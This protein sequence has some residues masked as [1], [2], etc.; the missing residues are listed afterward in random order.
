RLDLLRVM[1]W[2]VPTSYKFGLAE[3]VTTRSRAQI[4]NFAATYVGPT[5]NQLTAT[6][7]QSKASFWI[8]DAWG[9]NIGHLPVPDTEALGQLRF[10]HP[11]YYQKTEAN[12]A[13]ELDAILSSRASNQ[14]EIKAA[15]VMQQSRLGRWQ[16]VG[17]VRFEGTKTISSAVEPVPPSQNP[18]SV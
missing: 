3:R 2:Q 10:T 6:M 9:S 13:A 15:Y 16:L 18:Y 14:E 17:G 7:P 4:D 1:S 11:E 8:A 12:L 5:G